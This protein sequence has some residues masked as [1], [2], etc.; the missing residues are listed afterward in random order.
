[1]PKRPIQP[2]R[3]LP[4]LLKVKEVAEKVR[5]SESAV[6]RMVARGELRTYRPSGSG[7]A[8]LIYEQSVH[9]HVARNSYGAK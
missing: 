1:M 6:T 8:I 2:K 3:D 4:T 9:D 5:L 7:G